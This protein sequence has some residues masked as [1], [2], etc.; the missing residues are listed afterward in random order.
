MSLNEYKELKEERLAD[1][2][3]A[4]AHYKSVNLPGDT[5]KEVDTESVRDRIARMK[6]EQ[7]KPNHD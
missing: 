2:E 5:S 7:E 6:Q 1:G 3:K 4:N